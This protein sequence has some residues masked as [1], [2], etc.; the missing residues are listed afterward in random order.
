M[1]DGSYG[2]EFGVFLVFSI[3]MALYMVFAGSL[4]AF[5]T[6]LIVFNVTTRELTKRGKCHYLSKVR[7]NPFFYGLLGNV[8]AAM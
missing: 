3:F 8:K 2:Q 6:Y 4:L 5:H 7:G 1:S